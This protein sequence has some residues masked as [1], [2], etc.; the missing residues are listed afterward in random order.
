M[1]GRKRRSPDPVLDDSEAPVAAA[2]EPELEVELGDAEAA[3][4]DDGWGDWQ[5]KRRHAKF[6]AAAMMGLG[7]VFQSEDHKAKEVIRMDGNSSDGPDDDHRVRVEL[8][9]D[10]SKTRI[11][12]PTTPRKPS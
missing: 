6:A 5:P 10:P 7:E 3:E 4:P 12:L 2:I 8:G 9:S 11:H 1:F